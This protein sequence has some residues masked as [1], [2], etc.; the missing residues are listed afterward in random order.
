[1]KFQKGGKP[2]AGSGRPKGSLNKTTRAMKEIWLE[3][4]E[5]VGGADYLVAQAGA[6]PATFMQGLLRQIPNEVAA[7]VDG[8]QTIHFIDLSGERKDGESA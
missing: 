4:F 8:I 3:A 6:N 7:S 1:M 2:P 5:R